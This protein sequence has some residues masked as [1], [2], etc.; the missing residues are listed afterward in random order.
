MDLHLYLR[1]ALT[2]GCRSFYPLDVN[3][4]SILVSVRFI[5]GFLGRDLSFG[6]ELTIGRCSALS[7]VSVSIALI[8][9]TG[10]VSLDFFNL[11]KLGELDALLLCPRL[12][13][14]FGC[15]LFLGL[16]PVESP[17]VC[18]WTPWCFG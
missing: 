9:R 3:L 13:G 5:K 2:V 4:G 11:T 18:F 16:K 1:D 10:I 6:R 15:S 8:R 17:P 7:S 12:W 14:G